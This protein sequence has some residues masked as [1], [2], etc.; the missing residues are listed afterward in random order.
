MAWK[1]KF[2]DYWAWFYPAHLDPLSLVRAKTLVILLHIVVVCCLILLP[3]GAAFNSDFPFGI[4]I[5]G[6]LVLLGLYKLTQ[7]TFLVGN[8]AVAMVYCSLFSTM[9]KSGGIYSHDLANMY[10]VLIFAVSVTTIRSTAVWALL[11]F[12]CNSYFLYRSQDVNF[13][14]NSSEQRLG[15]PVEYYF[16]VNTLSI[17]LPFIFFKV[18]STLHKTYLNSIE[19]ANAKLDE[20]NKK[21]ASESR[22]LLVAK[23]QLEKSNLKLE[24][25]AHTVSHDLKQPMRTM[26]SFTQLLSK[27]INAL[28]I[29]DEK[30]KEYM[31]FV[32]SGTQRM[33]AQVDELLTFSMVSNDASKTTLCDVKKVI[34]EVLVDLSCQIK[35]TEHTI[36]IGEMPQLKVR[37]SNLSQVFQNL[38][39]NAFKYKKPTEALNLV[40]GAEEKTD[41]WL[42]SL[43]DN[44][45]GI[46]ADKLESIFD[47]YSQVDGAQEG[48][49][50]GLSSCKLI[51]TGYG[52]HIWVESEVN[53]GSTFFFSFPK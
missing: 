44:G 35:T 10:L 25:Y 29:E 31:G 20:S 19:E 15:F 12:A 30:V 46:E 53:V 3:A 49:G 41:H 40:V 14:Y 8:L 13:L 39:S 47:L 9:F 42:F 50:I 24:R 17:G 32:E 6:A 16:I 27:K 37:S 2:L 36:E 33:S 48:Q 23:S 4:S 1:S 5:I 34:E 26:S 45:L 38:I 11:C 21:L 18:F 51:I 28:D 52:G 22:N 43:T 7:S